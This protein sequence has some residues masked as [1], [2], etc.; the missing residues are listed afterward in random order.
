MGEPPLAYLA[1][2]W[3]QMGARLLHTT[4]RKVL[5]VAGEVGT[6]RKRHSIAHSSAPLERRPHS[7]DEKHMPHSVDSAQLYPSA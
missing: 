6:N 4:N 2:W 7:I 1:H 5:D 3:L